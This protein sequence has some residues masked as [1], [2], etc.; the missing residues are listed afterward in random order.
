MIAGN[1]VHNFATVLD[2]L[3]TES[4]RFKQKNAPI[5]KKIINVNKLYFQTA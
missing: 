4:F 3:V 5:I 2:E 1:T